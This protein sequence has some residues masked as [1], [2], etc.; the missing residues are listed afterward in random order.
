[1]PERRSAAGD[2]LTELLL[3]VF[4]LN[5]RFLDVAGQITQGTGL[6]AARWQVLGA[7]LP[8]PLSVASVARSMGLTRQSVQRLADVLVVEGL[9]EYREN[10]AHQRAKLLSP[11][12]D[13]WAAIRRIHP[14][15]VDWAN[16]VGRVV[17]EEAL[18]GAARCADAIL[19]TLEQPIG[20]AKRPKKRRS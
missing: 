15:Q 2:L 20:Q 6:T 5:G 4:R 3:K 10:P 18:L 13:G 7:V 9:C 8:G 14:I 12:S 11:T 1:M 17:G 19:E 16:R